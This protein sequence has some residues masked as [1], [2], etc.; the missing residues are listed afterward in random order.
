MNISL[1]FFAFY[2]VLHIV[3]GQKATSLRGRAIKEGPASIVANDNDV[4]TSEFDNRSL[5]EQEHRMTLVLVCTDTA[6]WADSQGYG[7]E[8]Y[9][10]EEDAGC[11]KNGNFGSGTY[12]GAAKDNCCHCRMTDVERRLTPVM[13]DGVNIFFPPT[14]TR[15]PVS[16]PTHPPTNHPVSWYPPTDPPTN[17]HWP[18]PTDPPTNWPTGCDTPNWEDRHFHGCDWYEREEEPGCPINGS[19][20]GKMGPANENCCHCVVGLF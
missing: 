16:S 3:H 5:Q 18:T 17:W 13:A 9:E 11:P 7:C 10:R 14:I 8:W 19:V 1:S 2:S 6:N 15:P 4:N 20:G 12:Q